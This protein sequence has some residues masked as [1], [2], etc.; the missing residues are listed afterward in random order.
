VNQLDASIAQTIYDCNI[1]I[2]ITHI[3]E[4]QYLIGPEKKNCHMKNDT[5]YVTVGGGVERFDEFVPR[6]QRKF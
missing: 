6:N 4:R 3:N 2:P 5:P 1:S